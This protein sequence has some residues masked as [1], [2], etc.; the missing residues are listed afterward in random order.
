MKKHYIIIL[1]LSI[2]MV[3]A[4]SMEFT[5]AKTYARI[6]KNLIQAEEWGLKALEKEPK[7]SYIAFFL[8]KEVYLPKNKKKE[9]GEMFVLALK[10]PDKKL[11]QPFR[12]GK[13]NIKTVHQE[14]KL[15]SNDFQNFAYEQYNQKNYLSTLEMINMAIKLDTTNSSAYMFKAEL[16]YTQ[17]NNLK[18]TLLLI[19]QAIEHSKDDIEELNFYFTKIGY[20]RK[21]KQ[22]DE[23]KKMLTSFLENSP[24]D[25]RTNRE[26]FLLYIDMDLLDQAINVGNPLLLIME[27][28]TNIEM[29]LISETA[30]ILGI[31]YRN[32]ASQI[33]NKI[34]A[35]QSDTEQTN[36]KTQNLIS[37]ANEAQEFYEVA[38]DY[39]QTSINYDEKGRFD[40]K[41]LKK[42]M[43]KMRKKINNEIIPLLEG[44]IK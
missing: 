44:F 43:R 28:D 31:C 32:K 29:D 10:L 42:D 11:E 6:E 39:F 27:E 1:L 26:L 3:H 30:Y 35:Y 15:R 19:N 2:Y 13:I 36:E 8:G 16:E 21:G 41:E 23:V 9:A 33:Y 40:A 37:S 17:N 7:N 25:I 5:S 4:R 22:Y 14:I 34:L 24:N 12:I 20:L 38:K 18:N